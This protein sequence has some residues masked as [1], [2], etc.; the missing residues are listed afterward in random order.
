MI[1]L[2]TNL[3]HDFLYVPQFG[4]APGANIQAEYYPESGNYT[5]NA[6]FTFTNHRHWSSQKFF[7]IRDFQLEARRYFKGGGEFIGPY[8]DG[9]LEFMK[10]GIG[11]SRTKG[12]QG[13]G[14]GAGIGAGYT[15]NLNKRG[16]LRLELSLNLGVFVTRYDP[17][18]WGDDATGWYYYDYE[19]DPAA[20]KKRNQRLLWW[21]PT[22][23][24]LNIGFDFWSRKRTGRADAQ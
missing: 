2:R 15:C 7:Q 19:G 12:W 9:Y 1:A 23:I 11:F 18:V 21:G 13:E 3:L 5:F 10:Y 4:F 14:G 24:Y 16:N 8:L 20:F 17:Y 22:R 6:G